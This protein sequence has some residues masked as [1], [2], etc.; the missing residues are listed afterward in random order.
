MLDAVAASRQEAL[1]VAT[2]TVVVPVVPAFAALAA[3][4]A[5]AAPASNFAVASPSVIRSSSN[6]QMITVTVQ[7]LQGETI[8]PRR[9]CET[10][11]ETS[12]TIEEVLTKF[13][14]SFNITHHLCCM[15]DTTFGQLNKKAILANI[16]TDHPE[17]KNGHRKLN[18]LYIRVPLLVSLSLQLINTNSEVVVVKQKFTSA[19]KFFQ[20]IS[21]ALN[22][23]IGSLKAYTISET[24]NASCITEYSWSNHALQGSIGDIVDLIHGEHDMLKEYELNFSFTAVAPD[25]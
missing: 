9:Y 8:L 23:E 15:E 12:I 17:E 2:A 24:S 18:V 20:A 13:S 6:I 11:L 22:V 14:T 21:T 7:L 10:F 25:A 16:P 5:A 4:A 1:D 19:M 3:A